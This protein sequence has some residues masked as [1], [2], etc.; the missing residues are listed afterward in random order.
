MPRRIV[1]EANGLRQA[2]FGAAAQHKVGGGLDV[3]RWPGEMNIGFLAVRVRSATPM[4]S[5]L[6][7]RGAAEPFSSPRSL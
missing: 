3:A 2:V 5:P 4:V 6:S 7:T 1:G